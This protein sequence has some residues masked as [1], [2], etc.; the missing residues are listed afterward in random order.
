MGV[1]DDLHLDMPGVL[2]IFLD[3]HAGF[4]EGP[5]RLGTG[6]EIVLAQAD[7]VAGDAHPLAAAAGDSLDQH[8]IADLL[9]QFQRVLSSRRCPRC[10]ASPARRPSSSSCARRPCRPCGG[11]ARGGADELDVAALADFGEVRVL[12]EEAVAGMDGVHIGHLRGADDVRDL[13]I[14]VAVGA[15]PMQMASS[16]SCTCSDRSSAWE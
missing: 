11:S 2:D 13:E 6:G 5:L 9:R 7:V 1:A 14:A 16:A 15:G 4:A 3:V 10:R 8:G 12:G